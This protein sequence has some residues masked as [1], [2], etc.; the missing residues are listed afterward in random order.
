MSKQQPKLYQVTLINQNK[1]LNKT[2]TV[3]SEEYILDA[4]EKQG[5]DLPAS[6]RAGACTSCTAKLVKGAVAHEHLFLTKEEEKKG[7]VLTCNAYPLSDCTII[8]H[9]E[10]ELLKDVSFETS[11]RF[12]NQKLS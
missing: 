12:L 5:I 3:S 2:I 6:C 1:K 10:D 8:T 4:A 9:Q 11:Y 7:F